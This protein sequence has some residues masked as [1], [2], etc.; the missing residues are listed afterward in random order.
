MTAPCAIEYI[1]VTR[2]RG[3]KKGGQ[4]RVCTCNTRVR[5][6]QQKIRVK[7]FAMP[8][9][10]EHKRN[11]TTGELL[12]L[13][14]LIRQVVDTLQFCFLRVCQHHRPNGIAHVHKTIG[15][16]EAQS[17]DWIG[18]HLQRHI[19]ERGSWLQPLV[20]LNAV[21]HPLV[22]EALRGSPAQILRQVREVLAI[23]DV[24]SML[25]HC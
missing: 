1:L 8:A 22:V 13:K 3:G 16:A 20:E 25:P 11:L 21:L 15:D 7:L 10:G 14:M 23:T 2:W 18:V 19:P 9:S 24:S 4:N 12:S 6:R 17:V 5:S